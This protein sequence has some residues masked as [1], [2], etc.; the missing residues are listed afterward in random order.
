MSDV[1]SLETRGRIGLITINNPPVNALGVDVR[2]GMIE[3]LQSGMSDDGID[4]MV[5]IGGGRTFIAGADIREFGKPPLSP[6]FPEVLQTLE[7][8]TKPLVAAIHGTA[9]GG[10]LEV[11]LTC[12]YRVAVSSARVGLPEVKLGILPGAGGT[13]R[14][15]RLVGPEAA[16]NMIVSGDPVVAPQ[17]HKMG[18]LD[19]VFD[20]DLAGQAIAFAESVV[21]ENKPLRRVSQLNDKVDGVDSAIF[22][23]YRK[24][25][26]RRAHGY[27]APW[28]C[29]DAVE[30]ACTL[31]FEQGLERERELFLQCME[32]PQRAAQMHMFFAEREVAKI[33]DVPKDTPVKDIKQVGIVGGGT[34]GGGIAMNFANAGIPVTLLEISQENLDR[35]LDIIRKNYAATVSKGRL[36]QEKMDQRMALITGALDYDAL[37]D[38][39]LVIEAVFEEMDLKKQVFA[40][41]DAACKPDAILATNTS[42]LDIDEIA[43]ATSRPEQVL[44][45]HF[46]SPAN[47]MKLLE[48]V[49]GKASSPETLATAMKMGK[50]I[51][52]TTVLVGNCDGFVGNR[53]LAPYLREANFLLDEG[54]L[55][56][57]VD[58]VITEFGFPM[59]P[60]TMGDMAGLDIGWRIRK[61]KA[62][63]RPND[64][65]YS[66]IADRICEQGRFGQ[67]T[68]A[69][70]YKYEPGNRTP[71]PDPEIEKLIIEASAEQGIERRAISDEEILTR[72]MYSLVN[73]AADILDE[74]IALR[75][76][77]VDIVYI[78]GYGFPPYRGGPM[79]WADS[80]GLDKVY[81]T[82]CGYRDVHGDFWMPSPLLERLANE[83]K[84]FSD[85]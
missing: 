36:S 58:R 83:G 84:R 23:T 46:F 17:A 85:L 21:A 33:P 3:A 43:A 56:Q 9:L 38:A 6:G 73:E 69:G 64:Q 57:D 82:I 4:A 28:R 25:I 7:N 26:E 20:D 14:L 29:I 18:I 54:A 8:A 13:Q 77:D 22:D 48:N 49:R 34:M 27:F 81:E 68:G 79:F 44:G 66:F 78:Y 62:A 41:L 50:A 37:A 40:K 74:G 19:A 76:S 55:P 16:L 10:G 24:Q 67:K 75:S 51:R 70:Y 5:I 31:P 52:K 72:C 42:T 71:I 80:I 1:V 35:G 63:S 2:R 47:V 32:S 30:A 60:F 45:T 12:H 61:A 39:D 11:S 15:P 53:M 65:R 59:G